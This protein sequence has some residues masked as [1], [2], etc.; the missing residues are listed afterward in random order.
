MLGRILQKGDSKHPRKGGFF[1]EEKRVSKSRQGGPQKIIRLLLFSC[2]QALTIPNLN[3][4]RI[5]AS[6]QSYLG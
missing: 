4:L 2:G 1:K 3:T 5:M 6:K